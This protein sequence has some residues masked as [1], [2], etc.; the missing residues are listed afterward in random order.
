MTSVVHKFV[1]P[2]EPEDGAR[3]GLMHII[4]MKLGSGLPRRL[5]DLKVSAIVVEIDDAVCTCFHKKMFSLPQ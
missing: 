2:Q 5:T 3:T 1:H 4:G